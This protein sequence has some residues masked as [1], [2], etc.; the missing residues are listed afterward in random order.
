[1]RNYDC[2]HL[3]YPS[4][5]ILLHNLSPQKTRNSS[6]SSLVRNDEKD[7]TA[8]VWATARGQAG[9]RGDCV[10]AEGG[11][12]FGQD[13]VK[14]EGQVRVTMISMIVFNS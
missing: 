14:L 1:M 8:Q 9:G 11:E 7:G 3:L 12:G 6:S 5:S 13:E 2:S 10:M 4:Y